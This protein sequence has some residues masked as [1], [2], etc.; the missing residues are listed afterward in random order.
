MRTTAIS[1][2]LTTMASTTFTGKLITP[3]SYGE[4]YLYEV[5]FS[6]GVIRTGIS[7]RIQDGYTRFILDYV[8]D[9]KGTAAG[10]DHWDLTLIY[11]N[12]PP[13]DITVEI[14]LDGARKKADAARVQDGM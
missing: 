6:G 2:D 7:P 8:T 5:N 3:S 11:K 4:R 10:T 13:H 12:S 9:A 14:W 1:T